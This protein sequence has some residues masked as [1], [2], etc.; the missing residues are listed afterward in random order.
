MADQ[1]LTPAAP[2]TVAAPANGDQPDQFFAPQ[3]EELLNK[4]YAEARPAEFKAPVKPS[5]ERSPSPGAPLEAEKPGDLPLPEKAAEKPSDKPPVR[6]AQWKE[7]NEERARLK[8]EN[9]KFKAEQE[10]YAK[11]QEKWKSWEK[12]RNEF[13]T[14]KKHN[15][16]LL[17]RMQQFAL[18]KDPRFEN[19]FKVKTDTAIALAKQAVG[20]SH[21]ERVSKLLQLPDSDWRTEQLETV[22]SE[23]GPTRQS[24]LGAAI[25]EM[26][27]INLERSVALSKSKENWELKQ[28]ADRE[29]EQG[30]KQQFERTFQDRLERWSDPEK[31]LALFQKKD[32]DEAHNTEVDKRVEHAR[33]ILNMNLSADEFS[34]AAL[35][36]SAAPGLLQ[37]LMASQEREKQLTAELE[38]LKAGGP[39]LQGGGE[40]TEV[41][42]EKQYE[43]MSMGEIIAA[44]VNK[45]GGFNR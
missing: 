31:G 4:A 6:A 38:A 41:D 26:D 23:L 14:I 39:E 17:D 3:M 1:V 18:E 16:E 44:K 27:R 29:R 12:E 42:D 24:R 22:M 11:E 9:A 20:D 37:T 32:G 43:G 8:E 25:V 35:W 45:A 5:S 19:Y 36:A 10:K 33:N 30:E 34:K 40:Q 2:A 28:K 7:V 13:E 21:A 15:A